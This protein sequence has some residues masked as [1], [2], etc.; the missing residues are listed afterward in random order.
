[1]KWEFKSKTSVYFILQEEASGAIKAANAGKIVSPSLDALIRQ[2]AASV[3]W[4]W[5]LRSWL[6]VFLLKFA[7]SVRVLADFNTAWGALTQERELT[8]ASAIARKRALGRH[9]AYSLGRILADAR[10]SYRCGSTGRADFWQIGKNSRRTAKTRL[11]KFGNL[12]IEIWTNKIY[13]VKWNSI[14]LA[15]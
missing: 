15:F 2:R 1:M 13:R 10:Y 12:A 4:S 11:L 7:S 5:G 6:I 9:R 14:N 3:P 8:R